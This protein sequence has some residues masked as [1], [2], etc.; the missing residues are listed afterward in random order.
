MLLP[1]RAE[2]GAVHGCASRRAR[3]SGGGSNG[4]MRTLKPS[5]GRALLVHRGQFRRFGTTERE[6][7][8][9]TRAG[10][11][12]KVRRGWWVESAEWMQLWPESQHLLH[13]LAVAEDA[14]STQAAA[15]HH[16]A[17]V[18]HGLPFYRTAFPRVHLTTPHGARISS[19]ADVMRH[20]HALA[21]TDVTLVNGI[22]CTTLERTVFDLI[23]TLPP[24]TALAVA[25][26]AMRSVAMF[27]R[28]YDEVRA[29]EWREELRRRLRDAAGA[30]G[31]R[32]GRWIIELADG[33][34][35][36][37]GE[38]VSRLQ[39]LRLGFRVL[40][41]Q[42]PVAKP[43]GGWYWVDIGIE[44]ADAWGEFDGATKYLDEAMR[45]GRTIEE[46]MLDEKAREDW[47]RGTT[48][49]PFARW[50]DA[51]IRTPG[52]LGARLSAF[53]IHPPR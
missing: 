41:L 20:V 28:R 9:R 39:L 16:S 34:A 17:G 35:Q 30:R 13:V 40:R 33:R 11:L 32:Q 5:E 4:V 42:V 29:E 18:L 24:E 15:S 53:G 45:S 52:A 7:V 25:D 22:R 23:R 38:S 6:L 2:S 26:G 50:G 36:L 3:T 27:G 12:H 21:E 43:Y 48:G 10:T 14:A 49:R 44:D 19:G 1:N 31:V 8:A 47:I 46:V 37:P 51:H